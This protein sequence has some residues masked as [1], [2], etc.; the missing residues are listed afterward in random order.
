MRRKYEEEYHSRLSGNAP[1][2]MDPTKRHLFTYD[3]LSFLEPYISTHPPNSVLT[4]ARSASPNDR[5]PLSHQTS[6]DDAQSG[7]DSR[8]EAN[9][10]FNNSALASNLNQLL[11][12][13]AQHRSSTSVDDKAK[14][15]GKAQKENEDDLNECIK[16]K[17]KIAEDPQAEIAALNASVLCLS[18]CL[19]EVLPKGGDDDCTI[20]GRQIAND[21]R[22]VRKNTFSVTFVLVAQKTSS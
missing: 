18:R 12:Q 16:R 11:M 8:N 2:P 21:L 9:E 20:F 1:T 19:E 14:S 15:L 7:R 3:Q 22:Q 6:S 5:A 13:L 4:A 10:E 17:R